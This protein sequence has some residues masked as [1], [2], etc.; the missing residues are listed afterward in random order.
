MAATPRPKASRH[1]LAAAVTVACIVWLPLACIYCVDS[2]G[3]TSLLLPPFFLACIVML[4]AAFW[5][6]QFDMAGCLMWALLLV[7]AGMMTAFGA[8]GGAVAAAGPAAAALAVVGAAPGLVVLVAVPMLWR[9][10]AAD[11]EQR[12]RGQLDRLAR[13]LIAQ[14]RLTAEI[15]RTGAGAFAAAGAAAHLVDDPD[16]PDDPSRELI[17]RVLGAVDEY[18]RAMIA[19]RLRSGR[20]QKAA[21]GGYAVG[22][23][24]CGRHA[25]GAERIPDE[26]DHAALARTA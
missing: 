5:L 3:W 8:R 19:L 9:H 20:E 16:D 18:E 23:P 2:G 11:W 25:H 12:V 22:G 24:P 7:F 1:R 10:G 14:E 4:A 21:S 13:D 6:P 17:R 26:R 15:R